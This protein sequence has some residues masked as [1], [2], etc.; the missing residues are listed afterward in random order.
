MSFFMWLE[1][2]CKDMCMVKKLLQWTDPM[3]NS[4]ADEAMMVL[5]CIESP[6]LPYDDVV[7]DESL[8]LIETYCTNPHPSN[9]S[10]TTVDYHW[11]E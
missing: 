1:K 11:S 5:N 2:Q 9:T 4:L 7:N 10:I 8:P 3:I 6:Q